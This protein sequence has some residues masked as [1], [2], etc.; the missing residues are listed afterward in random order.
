MPVARLG[1]AEQGLQQP[2][3]PRRG[4]EIAPAR[5]V[6]HA[7]QSVVDHNREMIA[8]RQI[9][10]AEDHVAPNL[11]RGRAVRG[12]GALAIFGPAE[13][14]CDGVDR[15]LHVETKRR[16]VAA[17]ETVARLS[18]GERAA[19]SRIERR[20]VRVAPAPGS[21]PDLRPAAEA[22]VDQALLIE[23][24]ERPRAV[25]GMLAL[26]AR[27]REAKAE[28]GKVLDNGGDKLR[29]GARAV[30]IFEPKEDASIDFRGDAF[31][32]KRRIG[33]AEMKRPIRRRRKAEDGG[34]REN[35]IDHGGKANP[36]A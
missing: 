15:A 35:F 25:P 29:L 8:R 34:S 27:R 9:P 24:R 28:P 14:R 13:M 20:P 21:A 3:D 18:R 33:V 36:Y 4:Q 19:R 6:R 10:A 12:N 22:R 5:D 7:L 23:A 30:Q 11:R 16:L 26:L 31:I 1:K 2:M 32:D 17:G